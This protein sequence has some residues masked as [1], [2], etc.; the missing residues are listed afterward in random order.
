MTVERVNYL[1]EAVRLLSYQR[2]TLV[3]ITGSVALLALILSAFWLQVAPVYRASATLTTL[4]SREEIRHT[5]G[6]GEY[7]GVNPAKIMS[8]TH[9]EYMLSRSLAEEVVDNVLANRRALTDSDM[10]SNPL[11][12]NI[13]VPVKSAWHG[14]LAFANY[15]EVVDVD[16]RDALV[17]KLRSRTSVQN[18]P[19][20]FVLRVTVAWD[21]PEI[22]A[23]AAN[24]ICDAYGERLQQDRD[25]R[26]NAGSKHLSEKMI[27]A[28][29]N[30]HEV[31]QR[32]Q[33]FKS[34]TGIFDGD[35]EVELKMEELSV[36]L[37]DFNDT[38][39][40]LQELDTKIDL[41]HTYQTPGELAEIKA[42]REGVEAR[43][44][45]LNEVI[46]EQMEALSAYPAHETEWLL[47]VRDKL[48]QEKVLDGL[49]ERMLDLKVVESSMPSVVQEIDRAIPPVYPS[50]PKVAVN[51]VV[52]GMAGFFLAVG[53]ALG[54][55]VLRSEVRT[56]ASLRSLGANV[57][58]VVPFDAG[59]KRW[60]D[61][62]PGSVRDELPNQAG[63]SDTASVVASHIEHL[64]R[65][66]L[67]GRDKGKIVMVSSTM[68][69]VGKSYILKRLAD[70]TQRAGQKVLVLD[71]DRREPSLHDAFGVEVNV[72]LSAVALGSAAL[73][74]AILRVTS[75]LDFAGST[76]KEGSAGSSR[77]KPERIED[78]LQAIRNEYDVI[79]VDTAAMRRDPLVSR[80]WEIAD[81]I[82]LVVDA[83]E[84]TVAETEEFLERSSVAKD[85]VTAVLNK[86]R[87]TGDFLF[88]A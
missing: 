80:I 56:A 3:A 76:A 12:S 22:A 69:N 16:P 49:R 28:K 39:V 68:S 36:S 41:L 10:P 58:G 9:T 86:V 48:D 20:S 81:E 67:G 37:R 59:H 40:R 1:G 46:N 51:T 54:T 84:T 4:P 73:K 83:Q 61:L 11:K 33:A 42:Q 75:T 8:Q 23:Q 19:G 25:A 24:L 38:K 17:A 53:F 34:K 71:L 27:E 45:G 62:K 78:E 52:G 15:G 35:R 21:D 72:P 85:R 14:L 77:W 2:K 31:D 44:N 74:E 63:D 65:T 5:V 18:I 7:F 70:S 82:L 66:V 47:L 50:N 32:I 60:N 57:N 29:M 55:N 87:Y 13:L 30:L 88:E 26:L 43:K 6:R 79:L 64:A